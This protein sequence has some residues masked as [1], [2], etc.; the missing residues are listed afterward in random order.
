MLRPALNGGKT[1]PDLLQVGKG[2]NVTSTI[3]NEILSTY[4]F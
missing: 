4:L 3:Q 2:K 1:C